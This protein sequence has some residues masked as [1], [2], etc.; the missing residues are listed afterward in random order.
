MIK[1]IK[2][3]TLLI[4]GCVTLFFAVLIGR[5]FWLQIVQGDF[6]QAHAEALWSTRKDLPATRGTITDRKGDV[7]AMDAPAYTVAINPEIIH[8][9]GLENEVA[10]GLSRILG[11]DEQ[12]MRELVNAKKSDGKYST[13][14]EVRNEGLK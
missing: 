12:E 14:R 6:W 13:H 4:G 3:R 5:V 1:R 7:L 11:K 10:E 9:K 8:A 2:L